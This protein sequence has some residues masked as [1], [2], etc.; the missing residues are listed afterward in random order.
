MTTAKKGTVF[1]F[2]TDEGKIVEVD[3]EAS[4]VDAV[5]ANELMRKLLRLQPGQTL[6]IPHNE[7]DALA[8]TD[9]D[10]SSAI[11]A[12]G[13]DCGCNG[14][15]DAVISA[16]PEVRGVIFTRIDMVPPLLERIDPAGSA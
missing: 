3:L 1:T 13:I 2:T 16:N 10:R 4:T 12:A 8:Q 9:L 11:M 15:L 6:A 7:L 14:N 5:A